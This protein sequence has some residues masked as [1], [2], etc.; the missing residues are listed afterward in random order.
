MDL[1][2]KYNEALKQYDADAVIK[3]NP[4]FAEAYLKKGI[5][6]YNMKK[7]EE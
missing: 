7:F 6:L 5:T 4:Q 1:T 3:V 2:Q